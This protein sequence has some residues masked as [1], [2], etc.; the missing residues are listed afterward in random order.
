MSWETL[1]PADLPAVHSE[2]EA[3]VPDIAPDEVTAV[4]LPLCALLRDK[5]DR[6]PWVV[7][8]A[9]SVAVGKSTT[10]RAIQALLSRWPSPGVVVVVGTDG[11]LLPN[12]ALAARGIP[13]GFP[14]SFDEAALGAFLADARAGVAGL[15]APV[16]DHVIYD[17]VANV[18]PV[19]DRPDVLIVEGVNAL[20][21]DVAASVDVALYIDAPET[22]IRDWFTH[23]FRR[24]A[25]AAHDDPA[26]F[27]HQWAGLDDAS[28]DGLA[29]AVW[30][31]VN[32]PNL[33]DHILPTRDRADFVLVKGADHRVTEIRVRH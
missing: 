28:L 4:Y 11:F 15:R 3:T 24:L 26:S 12:A 30:D 18:G 17:V 25:R 8:V 20:Q 27:Y 6:R 32:G 22:C 9:G 33:A 10:A 31:H 5:A 2:V 23:R 13:K 19:V 29:G 1:T 16:Y 7:G 14:D 21:P